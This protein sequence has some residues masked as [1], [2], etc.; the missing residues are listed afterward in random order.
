MQSYLSAWKN[1]VEAIAQL[2]TGVRHL[3]LVGRGP[4]LA[5][6]GTG[7]LIVKEPDHLHAEGMSSAAFHH[8]P[9][10]ML[11]EETFVLVFAGDSKTQNLSRKLFEDVRRHR[12]RAELV[13]DNTGPILAAQSTAMY[14][15]DP[16]DTT[17][18]NDHAGNGRTIRTRT[19][20]IRLGYEDHGYGIAGCPRL[21]QE[22]GPWS[23]SSS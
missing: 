10:E 9:F 1:H 5:A 23:P 19:G 22:T 3:F 7:S 2:L 17:R 14:S 6:V 21:C 8:G 13:S 16:G 18:A 12:G 15:S 11:N 20:T 4:S